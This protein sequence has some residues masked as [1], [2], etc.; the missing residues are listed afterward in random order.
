MA[1]N[2][3]RKII[4]SV[5]KKKLIHKTGDALI[6]GATSSIKKAAEKLSIE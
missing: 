2:N 1:G 6:N 3:V 4:N 5:D